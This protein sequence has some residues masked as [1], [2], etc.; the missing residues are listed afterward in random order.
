MNEGKKTGTTFTGMS[1]KSDPTKVKWSG[2][3]KENEMSFAQGGLGGSCAGGESLEES[4]K[5]RKS[6]MATKGIAMFSDKGGA[7]A[8]SR[9]NNSTGD[10]TGVGTSTGAGTSGSAT[11]GSADG[12][13]VSG[14]GDSFNKV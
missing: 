3:Y 10:A 5:K 7:T 12:G 1:G 4:K 9:F 2:K 13:A 11:S 6:S 14:G 8:I